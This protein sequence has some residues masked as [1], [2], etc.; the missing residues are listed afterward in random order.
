M[1][2]EDE[3]GRRD[4]NDDQVGM[5]SRMKKKVEK[6]G[7]GEDDYPFLS[8]SAYLFVSLGENHLITDPLAA[9]YLSFDHLLLFCT[10]V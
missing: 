7:D 2:K 4:G 10:P 5:K 9:H 3:R 1:G 6:E 8:F